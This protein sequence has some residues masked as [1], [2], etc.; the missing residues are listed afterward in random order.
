M[1]VVVFTPP[2]RVGHWHIS[3]SLD[4]KLDRVNLTEVVGYEVLQKTG[5]WWKNWVNDTRMNLVGEEIP[6][7]DDLANG[8]AIGD[9]DS[10]SLHTLMQPWY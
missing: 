1:Q 3:E 7:A 6:V 8:R 5:R 9:C 4:Y 2:K 10:V